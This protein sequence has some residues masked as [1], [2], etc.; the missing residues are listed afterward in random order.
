MYEKLGI[1]ERKQLKKKIFFFHFQRS[2]FWIFVKSMKCLK[3]LH[4]EIVFFIKIQVKGT[5]MHI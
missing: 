4:Y 1:S 2:V 5:L 3:N